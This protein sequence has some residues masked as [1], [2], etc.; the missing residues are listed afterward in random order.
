MIE[1]RV[2]HLRQVAVEDADDLRRGTRFREGREAA[3][4]AE[5][6]RRMALHAT[7]AQVLVGDESTS[8]T[9]ASGTKRA[10][11]SRRR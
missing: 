8:P 2:A 10:N 1:D 7:Q 11:V 9:T 6:D 5:H 3:Q 4:I